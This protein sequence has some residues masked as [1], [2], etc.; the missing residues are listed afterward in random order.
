MLGKTPAH[1]NEGQIASNAEC[2]AGFVDRVLRM[3]LSQNLNIL[4]HK[5]K[6]LQDIHLT[7][8]VYKCSISRPRRQHCR[9]KVITRRM[10]K[11]TCTHWSALRSMKK[12]RI[13]KQKY[14]LIHYY[15]AMIDRIPAPVL[16][17]RNPRLQRESEMR[18]HR[19]S[20]IHPG[21]ITQSR[22]SPLV[23]KSLADRN[24]RAHRTEGV[25]PFLM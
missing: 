3:E 15:T 19:A 21:G 11:P 8:A 4:L 9:P 1:E 20:N 7:L 5:K 17:F 23:K 6:P 12:F 10:T 13:Q 25:L 22:A 2:K 24:S 18:N 16:L 14:T